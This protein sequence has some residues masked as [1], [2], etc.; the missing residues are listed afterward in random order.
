M[1]CLSVI[2]NSYLFSIGLFIWL[3][4]LHKY[5]RIE[6]NVFF[7]S[8]VISLLFINYV[9][10]IEKSSVTD[11]SNTTPYTT[12]IIG[13]INSPINY[14]E[15]LIEFNFKTKDP[16]YNYLAIYFSGEDE[17]LTKQLTSKLQVGATCKITGEVTMPADNT[18]PG[19]FNY[20][21][22]LQKQGINNQFVIE[23]LEHIQCESGSYLGELNLIREQI[24]RNILDIYDDYT[25]GWI[26]AL[27]LGNDSFIADET[28]E[29]FRRWGLSHLL[30]ISGLHVGLIIGL[31]YFF[32]IKIGHVTKERAQWLMI[33]FLPIYAV[34]AGGEPSV[35]RASLMAFLFIVLNKLKLNFTVTDILSIIFITLILIDKYII[36]HVG[37]QLSFI[38]TFSIILSRTWVM[39][40]S[41]LL[42]QMLKISFIS[43]M[44]IL[45]LQ[46]A[47]FSIV[48]P[49][50]I[51]LNVI[52][53]PY[54]SFLI[55]PAMFL[56]MILSPIPLLPI[57]FDELFLNIHS[58]FL[59]FLTLIDQKV[60]FPWVSGPLPPWSVIL[61]YSLL[62]LLMSAI[63]RK[64][65]ILA[66]HCGTLIT[67]TITFVLLRPY[68]SPYGSVT[69][70]DIGQGDAFVIELPYRKGVIFMDAGSTFSF[71][72]HEPSDRVYKQ[73][74]K[75]YLHSQGIQE[76]DT[77]FIS[78]KHIDH[79]GSV[80][81]L[82]EDFDTKQIV[83]SDYYKLNNEVEKNWNE[84][85][86]KLRRVQGGERVII[87]NVIFNILSPFSNIISENDN[88]LV[89]LAEL[90]GKS[91]LFTGDI[92][93][94]AEKEL[95]KHYPNLTIDVLKVAHHGSDTSS[96]ELFIENIK[97]SYALI[98]VGENNSY[99][100]PDPIV[101]EN[102]EKS[103][104]LIMRTDEDGAIIYKFNDES[105]IFYN[106]IP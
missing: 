41:S 3:A 103:I 14:Q 44:V 71:I 32:L 49:A 70:L 12:T 31:V 24:Q 64:K 43:Q 13:E 78:H 22:Y 16:Q 87:N 106:Y 47:Y 37:F 59:E 99:G 26:I 76:I 17:S 69:M 4:L 95:I 11:T 89:A 90:G 84:N 96:D 88:S 29:L 63:L 45:P 19:Q 98:S 18:N 28:I 20:R 38:V 61:Y 105:G 42:F 93:N 6:K 40:N 10:S 73:I 55:I 25:A 94:D 62:V 39:K 52:V 51:L 35:W 48:Q 101:I 65:L 81:F 50:S 8:L 102:L 68:F 86:V 57:I 23:S 66:F 54:F 60:N 1:T 83:I 2:F 15:K 53:V 104:P 21:S 77:I 80:D 33:I 56:L 75:P 79:M 58:Y 46:F 97:P 92:E 7:L 9:P 5:K 67:L 91:W 30:A 27:V 74:I 100:H 36:Y 85:G 82:I 72:D 34:I